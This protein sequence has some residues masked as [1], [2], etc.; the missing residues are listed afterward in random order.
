MKCEFCNGETRQK[1]VKRQHWL[2]GVLT[3]V[4][5]V[6]AEVCAECGERYFHARTLDAIDEYLSKQHEVKARLEVE[7]VRLG[8]ALGYAAT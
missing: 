5:N 6:S 4:E 2:N 1:R 8:S 3:I 7:V